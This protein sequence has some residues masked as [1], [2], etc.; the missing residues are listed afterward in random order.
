MSP[1]AVLGIDC[2]F[3]SVHAGLGTYTRGLVTSL[4]RLAPDVSFVLFVRSHGEE[5]LQSLPRQNVRCVVADFPHYSFLEQVRFPRLI[6]SSGC[7]LFFAPQFNVPLLCPVPFI[8]TVHNLILHHY[9]NEGSVL[10]RIAYRFLLRFAVSRARAVFTVSDATRQD[11]TIQYPKAL[12]KVHRVYPGIDA[13]P[14]PSSAESIVALRN[15]YDV[16][17]PYFLYVGNCKEHKNVPLLIESFLSIGRSSHALVLVCSGTECT[18][19]P[20][21][22]L[23]RRVSHLDS[24][25][26]QAFYAGSTALVTATSIEG[27]G[28]PV[29]EA[30]AQQCPVIATDVPSIREISGG[31][32]DLIS[33]D[34]PSLR[35]ALLRRLEGQESDVVSASTHARTFTWDRSATQMLSYLRPLFT[36]VR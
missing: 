12:Q 23:I 9:T 13:T 15:K 4:V 10:K 21:H 7:T 31:Y 8:C 11:L 2:R 19:L 5:W 32:A 22:P 33:A 25:D 3:A 14:L 34:A 24:S 1:T 28:L 18:K 29:L 26:L 35:T 17:L 27:F 30:M 16:Q 6:R 36:S 20:T